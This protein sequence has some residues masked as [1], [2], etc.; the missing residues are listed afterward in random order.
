MHACRKVGHLPIK[1]DRSARALIRH[2]ETR[3]LRKREEFARIPNRSQRWEGEFSQFEITTGDI[4]DPGEDG[5]V[6]V[7]LRL[8]LISELV[9]KLRPPTTINIPPRVNP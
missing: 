1:T 2:P 5:A 3:E 6:M 8:I 7:H 9:R 4:E